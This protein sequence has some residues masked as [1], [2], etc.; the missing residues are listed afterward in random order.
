[1]PVPRNG[2]SLPHNVIL[3]RAPDVD[4]VI[5]LSIPSATSNGITLDPNKLEF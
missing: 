5:H 4:L 1:M 2:T 3:E